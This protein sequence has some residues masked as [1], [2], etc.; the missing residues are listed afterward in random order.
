MTL[1]PDAIAR[2]TTHGRSEGSDLALAFSA[3]KHALGE[4]TTKFGG[5]KVTDKDDGG[6]RELRG[7]DVGDE[8]RNNGASG[9]WGRRMV[10]GLFGVL[11]GGGGRREDG[12]I[13]SSKDFLNVEGVG[14]LMTFDTDNATY[15]KVKS[16]KEGGGG[17]FSGFILLLQ[18]LG[19]RRGGLCNL[20]SL[21]SLGRAMTK[22]HL[23][24]QTHFTEIQPTG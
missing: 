2:Q 16:M 8:T 15:T 4:N 9:L 5:L 24:H 1:G 10:L 6:V 12:I 3:Q 14:A 21:R 20:G 22:E 19:R 11:G 17:G 18:G 7:G 13:I 23:L